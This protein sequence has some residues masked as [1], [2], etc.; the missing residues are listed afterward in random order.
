VVVAGVNP[1]YGLYTGVFAPV[2]GAFLAGSSLMVI[3]A[4]N[5]LAVPTAGILASLGP[6]TRYELC[7]P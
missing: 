5:E 2:I 7:S 1:V 6:Q 3:V 4:T